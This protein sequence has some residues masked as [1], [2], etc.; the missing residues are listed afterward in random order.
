MKTDNVSMMADDNGMR[1]VGQRYFAKVVNGVLCLC[2]TVRAGFG[3]DGKMTYRDEV[4]S[5]DPYNAMNAF[6]DHELLS[7]DKVVTETS[8]RPDSIVNWALGHAACR[9]VIDGMKTMVHR[10]N[11][12][13]PHK[14]A[15][16]LTM[17][18]EEDVSG[19]TVEFDRGGVPLPFIFT[20]FYTNIREDAAAS[21]ASGI[22]AIA[23]KAALAAKI[24]S[25]SQDFCMVNGYGQLQYDGFPV[26]GFRD[27]PTGFSVGVPNPWLD[28]STPTQ[29]V[30][31]AITAAVTMLVT[32]RIPGP[33]KLVVPET[34]RFVFMRDYFR[35]PLDN[36]S[37]SLYSRIMERPGP[38]VPNELNI[39]EI[40]F[41]AQFNTNAVGDDVDDTE[42]YLMSMSPEYFNA[43]RTLPP[44]TFTIDLKG[45]IS[46]K[47]RVASGFTPLWRKNGKNQ[48]GVVRFGDI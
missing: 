37:Q 32:A 14:G 10:Y 2:R 12:E 48:Y 26:Y 45:A 23:E 6:T 22:D 34:Y 33:Y 46:T 4:V 17:K 39:E 47:H 9:R 30:L 40:H 25:E 7:I 29:E 44:T 11:I 35:S 42:A 1:A 19:A 8:K 13:K 43:L 3:A 21:R 24:V 18:L 20:D 5:S 28:P 16:R 31:D 15:A 27:N 38:G 36:S 41:N